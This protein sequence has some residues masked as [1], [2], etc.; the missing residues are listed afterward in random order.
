MVTY[1]LRNECLHD[2]HGSNIG[3]HNSRLVLYFCEKKTPIT[4]FDYSAGLT[5]VGTIYVSE[6]SHP[7]IRPVLLC[8]NSIFVSL[9]ILLTCIFGTLFDWQSVG[10]LFCGLSLITGVLL[11]FIPESPRWLITFRA[12][13]ERAAQ[14]SIKWIYK[15]E[16]V[17]LYSV[18]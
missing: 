12:T 15:S 6:I 14:K 13:N 9:G 2:I 8:F 3:G 17:Y 18:H 16:T 5:N 1:I 11:L 4:F 7:S 10:L